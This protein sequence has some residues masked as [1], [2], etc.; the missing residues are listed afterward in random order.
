MDLRSQGDFSGKD[1]TQIRQKGKLRVPT[2]REFDECG[3]VEVGSRLLR[4][5][6]VVLLALKWTP[7]HRWTVTRRWCWK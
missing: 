3:M 4:C 2:V 6:F 1:E 7:I 5:D